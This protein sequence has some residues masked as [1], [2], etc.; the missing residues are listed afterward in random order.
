MIGPDQWAHR[1]LASFRLNLD[2][3][4]E[5]K[6]ASVDTREIFPETV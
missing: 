3:Q 2:R 4:W 1:H 5:L 6:E